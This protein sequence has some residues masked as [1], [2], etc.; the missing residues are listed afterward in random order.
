MI[1]GK[2]RGA[3]A[4][5]DPACSLMNRYCQGDAE[6]F[7]DLYALLA[8]V[9][10]ADLASRGYEGERAAPL[11]E[12][13]FLT[14]HRDRRLYVRGA[15]PRPWLLAIA[16]RHVLA[17]FERSVARSSTKPRAVSA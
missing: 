2:R 14:L 9:V 16:R 7:R 8:P 11:L 1:W 13:A 17:A 12:A 3:A 6:A 4:P 15:D 5:D 10:L